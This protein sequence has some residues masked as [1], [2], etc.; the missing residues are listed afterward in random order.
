VITSP[1][2][3]P[4]PAA[5]DPETTP[6]TGAPLRYG[7]D[8]DREDDD[9]AISTPR[10]AVGPM[11]TVDELWPASIWR[12]KEVALLIGMAKPPADEF[13]KLNRAEPAVSMAT[14]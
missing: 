12:A 14:T 6:A 9:G 10:K 8:P 5:G 4:D 2:A 7:E 13:R 1:A 11:C 3:S